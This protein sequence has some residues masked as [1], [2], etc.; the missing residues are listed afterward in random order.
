MGAFVCEI[1]YGV[2][3]VQGVYL[4]REVE[5]VASLQ[6]HF[7]STLASKKHT[8]V[9]ILVLHSCWNK[10]HL[11]MAFVVKLANHNMDFGR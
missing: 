10:L 8:C 3:L 2:K 7:P 9:I 6:A 5:M 4:S 1:S 11:E